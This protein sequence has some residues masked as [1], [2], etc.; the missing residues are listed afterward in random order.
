M[1][2]VTYWVVEIDDEIRRYYWST[3]S[4]CVRQIRMA[5]KQG[6]TAYYRIEKTTTRIMGTYL[7]GATPDWRG[8]AGK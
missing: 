4:A 1:D 7:E 2:K 8:N 6:S 5:R 3:Y